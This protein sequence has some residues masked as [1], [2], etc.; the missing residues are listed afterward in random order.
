MKN[1]LLTGLLGL[2]LFCSCSNEDEPV[3]NNPQNEG[4]AY[5]QIMINVASTSTTRTTT[6]G[7]TGD[8]VYGEDNEYTINDIRVVLAD[9]ATNIA[10]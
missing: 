10:K 3:S 5:T 9:P 2:G 1:L 4:T 6:D 8:E 7:S